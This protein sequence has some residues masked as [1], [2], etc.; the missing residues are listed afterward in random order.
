MSYNQAMHSP[1]PLIST[2]VDQPQALQ[3]MVDLLIQSPVLAVDTESNSLFAYHEQICLIQFSTETLDFLVDPLSLKDLSPLQILFKD[4]NIE[5]IFHAAEY[6]LICLKRDLGITCNHLFDTMLAARILGHEAVG[7]GSL[8]EKEFGFKVDKRYQRANWGK[9]PLTPEMLAYA[10]QDT[11]Y[12][13]PLRRILGKE[14]EDR[15]LIELAEEDFVRISLVTPPAENGNRSSAWKISSSQDL[16]PRQMTVLQELADYRE[17]EAHA[18][19]RPPFKVLSNDILINVA[20]TCPKDIQSLTGTAHINDQLV[21][22]YGKGLLR[23]VKRG[24][25]NPI[26]KRDPLPRKDDAFIGRLDILRRWRKETANQTH[27]ESDVILPREIMFAIAEKNPKNL[28]ELKNIMLSVPW[29]LERFGLS[30][31]KAL[32]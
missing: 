3:N 31:L 14:L 12:L 21:Q 6:D 30:I 11:H 7:L 4:P 23:A 1:A 24:L 8:I 32:T 9:R 16:S 25:E 17:M 29:R 26:I 15:Q 20:R 27:V 2:W 28:D 19:N 18:I 13:I 5:K 10:Q 22:R